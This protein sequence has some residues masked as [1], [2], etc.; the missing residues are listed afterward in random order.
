MNAVRSVP[1]MT[2]AVASLLPAFLPASPASAQLERVPDQAE[3]YR[4]HMAA[5]ISSFRLNEPADARRWLDAAPP[6]LRGWEWS[7]LDGLFDQSTIIAAG[8]PSGAMSI[9]IHP[10]GN[11]AAVAMTGGQVAVWDLA[12]RAR[13]R[14]L[15]AHPGGAFSV[16][17]SPDGSRL[18]SVGY[19]RSA[20]LV[21][22]VSYEPVIEF[23]EHKFPVT[24]VTFTADGKYAAT[25]AYFTDPSTPIEGRVYLWDAATGAIVRSFKGGVKPLSGLAISPS[26]DRIAA[27]SWDSCVFVW[28]LDQGGEPIRLGGTTPEQQT[29]RVHS[30]SFSPD[31]AFLAAGSDADWIKVYRLD[32]GHEVA[33]MTDHGADVRAVAF[34]PDGTLL[35]TGGEEGCIRVWSTADWSSRATLYG[36]TDAVLSLA[37][38][39]DG[40]TLYSGGGDNTLRSWDARRTDLAGVRGRAGTSNYSVAFTSDGRYLACSSADGTVGL[41]DASTGDTA[42]RWTAH[43]DR[44]ACT[45]TVSPDLALVA[46]CSWDK[47]VRIFDARTHAELRKVDL[48]AGV[49]LIAWHP[50]GTHIAA[51]LTNSTAVLID[52]ADGN[53]ARTLTGHKSR[54]LTVGFDSTGERLVTAGADATAK[55]WNVR[56]GEQ[57]AECDGHES[58]IETAA[59]TI[60]GSSVLTG[61]DDGS[62]RLWDASTGRLVRNLLDSS[63]AIYRLAP[64]P[65]GSRVAA[66]GKNLYIIDPGLEAPVLKYAPIDST[67]WH[68]SWSPDGDRL[69]VTSWDG[70]FAV[71]RGAA[72]PPRQP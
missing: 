48:P 20:R 70:R 38:S 63:D 11:T 37:W 43:P 30:I 27:G 52:A 24:G 55:I 68:V 69:A 62:V 42:A 15:A 71:L 49:A 26:G 72:R 5:A 57:I 45:A 6:A 59:F 19:D 4:A 14:D 17:F 8:L 1:A 22:T 3:S 13:V 35:A 39:A 41:V 53:V 12:A 67:L 44:E 61:S 10:D 64:S 34:S 28:D 21:D 23:K 18:A 65:D 2:I 47:T 56:T 29:V 54:V 7:Y 25:S 40:Q 58:K 60:D 50:A 36:H 16:R 33:T 51:A 66:V 32:D 31:G 9:S 46:T